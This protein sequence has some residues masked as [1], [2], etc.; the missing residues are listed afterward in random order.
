VRV[1]QDLADLG[2]EA[3]GRA[4]ALGDVGDRGD[5]LLEAADR[6]PDALGQL[7]IL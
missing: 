5:D 6:V 7:G 1:E 4:F 3:E 2:R